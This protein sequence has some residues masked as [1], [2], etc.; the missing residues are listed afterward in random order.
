MQILRKAP[1]PSNEQANRSEG[2]RSKKKESKKKRKMTRAD[3]DT[4]N[5]ANRADAASRP[6]AR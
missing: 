6:N 4:A 5:T 3:A 1:A 2:F